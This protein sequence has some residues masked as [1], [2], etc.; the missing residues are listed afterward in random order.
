MG[1]KIC[2]QSDAAG[3]NQQCAKTLTKTAF[4]PP[5]LGQFEC[6][7]TPMG[8]FSCPESFQGLMEK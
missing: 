4:N 3:H 2:S 5:G 8:L 6:L 7:M 1:Q